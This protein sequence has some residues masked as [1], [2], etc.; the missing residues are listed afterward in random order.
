MLHQPTRQDVLNSSRD[1]QAQL[2][3]CMSSMFR[4]KAIVAPDTCLRLNPVT[5]R[6]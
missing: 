3:M 2:F 5:C 4:K 1:W 6:N